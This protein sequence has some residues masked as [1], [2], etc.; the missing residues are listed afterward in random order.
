MQQPTEQAEAKARQ[1]EAKTMQ[2]EGSRVA[3]DIF[4]DSHRFQGEAVM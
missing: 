1:R 2:R 4:L 3:G